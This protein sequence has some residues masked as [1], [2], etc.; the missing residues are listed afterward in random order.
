MMAI[1]NM[2]LFYIIERLDGL[3][4]E[5]T[6]LTFRGNVLQ[7]SRLLIHTYWFISQV[8]NRQNNKLLP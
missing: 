3:I 2:I 6:D 4:I 5:H 7:L 8:V 1:Q